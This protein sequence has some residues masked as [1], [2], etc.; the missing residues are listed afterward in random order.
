[1]DW[2]QQPQMK[3]PDGAEMGETQ[4]EGPTTQTSP[5]RGCGEAPEQGRPAGDGVKHGGPRGEET[6]T[7][8]WL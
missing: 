4:Q 5:V 6:P 8:T 3:G 2:S 7:L 1:M